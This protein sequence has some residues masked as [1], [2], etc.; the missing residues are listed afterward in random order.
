VNVRQTLE[1]LIKL[2]SISAVI[3]STGLMQASWLPHWLGGPDTTLNADKYYKLKHTFNQALLEQAAF[4]HLYNVA[5]VNDGPESELTVL[6]QRLSKNQDDIGHALA[7]YYKRENGN[8]LADLLKRH[9]TLSA[10]AAQALVDNNPTAIN[11]ITK[12][13]HE[14]AGDIALFLST[15]N[16]H[17]NH[18]VLLDKLNRYIDLATQDVKTL[19][20]RNWNK[21]VAV[22]DQALQENL[23][24][25]NYITDGIINQFHKKFQ[26]W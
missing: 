10:E 17:W 11:D 16:K 2:L 26:K 6:K 20:E 19:L 22:F 21:N 15:L 23:K 3:L 5:L 7:T 13:W 12:R 4:N 24:V 1:Y 8:R 25:S 9:V 14:H 18:S